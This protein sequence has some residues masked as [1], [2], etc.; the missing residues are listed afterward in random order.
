MDLNEYKQRVFSIRNDQDFDLLSEWAY[1][2]QIQNCLPYQKYINLLNNSNLASFH[3]YPYLP[4]ELFKQHD[5]CDNEAL[6]HSIVFSSSN[7]GGGG[8]SFHKVPDITLY[9]NSFRLHFEQFFNASNNYH[10][11]GLLP[12]YLERSGSSLVYMA[13]YLIRHSQ[14]QGNGF[15]LYEFENLYKHLKKLK[16]SKKATILLGVTFALLDFAASFAFSFPELIIIETGGMK[17]RKKEPLRSEVHDILKQAFE[18]PKVYSEY[19][20]TELLSQAYSSDGRHFIAPKW[21]KVSAYDIHDP[22]RKLDIGQQG[23]ICIMDLANIHSCCFIQTSDLGRVYENGSF[24][25]NGRID[26]SD[27]RGCSL[28]SLK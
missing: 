18:V 5:V 21:M 7:T 26:F 20:M 22:F 16:E 8:Q 28:L 14:T 11:L 15:Y 3:S 2:Y 6:N 19:G 9:E 4:V 1:N 13:D 24:E 12:S 25:I 17:G 10:I 27:L 23:R